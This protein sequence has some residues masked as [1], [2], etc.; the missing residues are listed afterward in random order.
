[1]HEFPKAFIQPPNHIPFKNPAPP[2]FDELSDFRSGQIQA[3]NFEFIEDEKLR[4][5]GHNE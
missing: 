3:M 1:M 2:G 5:A 4:E